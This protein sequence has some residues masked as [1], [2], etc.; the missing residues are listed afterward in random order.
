[1]WYIE[2]EYGDNLMLAY[3]N[4]TT[5]ATAAVWTPTITYGN[6]SQNIARTSRIYTQTHRST[7][8]QTNS[9][10]VGHSTVRVALCDC[11]PA[12][13]IGIRSF[14]TPCT[15]RVH[16][17]NKFD[18]STTVWCA[19]RF[20]NS[21]FDVRTPFQSTDVNCMRFSCIICWTIGD[22]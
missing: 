2:C 9:A 6:S 15:H 5:L 19:L 3:V 14:V 12:A 11:A 7:L 17:Q 13:D 20:E 4:I 8:R 22:N 21:R 16:R 18:I 1:M 10:I